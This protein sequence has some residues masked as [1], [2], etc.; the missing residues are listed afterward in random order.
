[1]F[2]L[3]LC[4]QILIYSPVIYYFSHDRLDTSCS[5]TLVAIPFSISFCKNLQIPCL[6]NLSHQRSAKFQ[7]YPVYFSLCLCKIFDFEV[8][9]FDRNCYSHVIPSSLLRL[10]RHLHNNT[11]WCG[12]AVPAPPSFYP[13]ANIYFTLRRRQIGKPA[14]NE[15]FVRQTG[16]TYAAS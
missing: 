3:I 8:V 12:G 14:R 15:T 13:F 10:I 5:K 16:K 9:N 2:F 7:C 1:M 6:E 11:R 4:F